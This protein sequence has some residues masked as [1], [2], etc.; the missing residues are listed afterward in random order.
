MIHTNIL[1]AY[2]SIENTTNI[3]LF[4]IGHST[5]YMNTHVSSVL[6]RN[7]LTQALDKIFT[8]VKVILFDI[9]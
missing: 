9:R 8:E 2:M 7:E 3:Y 4:L 1:P 6:A 5:V